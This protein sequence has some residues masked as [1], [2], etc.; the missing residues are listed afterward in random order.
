MMAEKAEGG[1][2]GID[3]QLV[4][5]RHKLINELETTSTG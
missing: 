5:L 1:F 3:P 2:D 4:Q